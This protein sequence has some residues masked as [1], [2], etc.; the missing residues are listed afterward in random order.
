LIESLPPEP[1]GEQFRK[2]GKAEQR[3]ITGI[4]TSA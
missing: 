1:H 4:K 2:K 3:F